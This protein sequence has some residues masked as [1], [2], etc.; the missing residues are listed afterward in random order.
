M[1]YN[2]TN[3]IFINSSTITKP[4]LNYEDKYLI[5][6][7]G[8]IINKS[9][10]E[11]LKTQLKYKDT[12][13][14]YYVVSLN[15]GGKIKKVPIHK[16]MAE[17]FELSGEGKNIIHIDGNNKNN[18]IEN[19]KYSTSKN[20]INKQ[21][22]QSI[23]YDTSSFRDIGMIHNIF[24]KYKINIDGIIINKSN[25]IINPIK[26]P[27]GEDYVRLSND[28]KSINCRVDRLIG[29]VFLENGDKYFEDSNY[30]LKYNMVGD[31]KN[32]YWIKK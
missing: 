27:E 6:S 5:T 26:T 13:Y 3:Q 25:K 12:S 29:K 18:N 4:L 17:N 15:Y 20:R 8:K 19:L 16:L 32:Y 1:T 10:N 31:R 11:P 23:V 30:M 28:N 2:K 14:E 24:Y 22:P 7:E 21:N 9:T